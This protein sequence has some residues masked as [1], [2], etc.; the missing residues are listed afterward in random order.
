MVMRLILRLDPNRLRRWHVCLV[1]RLEQRPNVELS[2]EWAETKE[3]LPLT[4]PLLFALER[5]VYG[6]P[7]DHPASAAEAKDLAP[8][9]TAR[10]EHADLVLDFSNDNPQQGERTWKVTFDGFSGEVA[11][12]AALTQWRTPVVAVIDASTGVEIVSGHPGT[13]SGGVLVLAFQDVLARTATLITAALDGGAA[14]Q[15]GELRQSATTSTQAVTRF[16]VRS[17][18]RALASWLYRLCYNAPHWRVGWRF[19]DGADV[20]DLRDHP[21]GVWCELPDDRRRFYADPFPIVKNGRTYL[22]VEEF[23]HRFGLG[24]ISAVEFDG[25]GPVG[26]PR[27]VLETAFHLFFPLVFEHRGQI[28]MVPESCNA[29]TIDLYRG[30]PFPDRWVKEATLVS[31]LVASDATLFEHDGRWWMLATV[32]DDGGA[33]SDALYIWSA[34]D[35]LGPWQP[36]RRNPLLVDI[37]TARPAGRVVRRGGKLIRPFQ[38]CRNGYGTALGL[39]EITRL[40]DDG[41]SQRVETLLRPGPLWPGRKLHTLNRAERLEC[42]DGSAWSSKVLQRLRPGRQTRHAGTIARVSDRAAILRI[43]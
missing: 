14:M 43:W 24:V 9:L 13:E 26:K 19:V 42:I 38:D 36:H 32:R 5:L 39:A 16:A 31:G 21:V 17:L 30:A 10:R 15:V 3:K 40:D 34:R 33:Y 37:A 27:P 20:I 23:E 28:W 2:I 22:F 29:K 8:F 4:I 6:L 18:S 11:A 35:L 7:G 1:E 12:L 41:F 25:T